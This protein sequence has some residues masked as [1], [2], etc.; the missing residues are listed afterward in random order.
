MIV[1]H[2]EYIHKKYAKYHFSSFLSINNNHSAT[3]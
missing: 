3:Q 2:F 1:H